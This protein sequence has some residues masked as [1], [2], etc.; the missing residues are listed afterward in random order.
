MLTGGLAAPW[1]CAPRTRPSPPESD[2]ALVRTEAE[3][4][5]P[6]R[7]KCGEH[8]RLNRH[9]RFA[10]LRRHVVRHDD[11]A[12]GVPSSRPSTRVAAHSSAASLRSGRQVA[13]G[14]AYAQRPASCTG[15]SSRRTCSWTPKGVVWI[16][17]FG[18]AKGDDEGLTQT[19]DIL[20]TIRY[21]APERFRG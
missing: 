21:M 19:G 9:R 11:L 8:R 3:A 1:V 14:L 13:A 6:G 20:G 18:L 12:L 10:A 17:D 4:A 15:T 2:P 5:T 7:Y 16:T